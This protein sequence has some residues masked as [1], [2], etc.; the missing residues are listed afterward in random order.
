MKILSVSDIEIGF[1]YSPHI[2]DRFKDVDLI[3]SCGD[4]PFYYLEYIVS[5]LNRPLY[6]VLGNHAQQIEDGPGGPRYHPWGAYDLHA[7]TTCYEGLL[8]AGMQGSLQ[9]N[10]GPYQYTQGEMWSMVLRLAPA[11]FLNRVRYGRY[12]D[13]FVSHA[14]PWDVHDKPDRPHRG[15][16]AFRWLH[17]VFRPAYHLHGHIHV[18]RSDTITETLLYQTRVIN[19]YGYRETQVDQK[20]LQEARKNVDAHSFSDAEGKDAV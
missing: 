11:L 12:L 16:K 3:I 1:I 8:L 7:R 5:V 18:Y 4:L 19:T 20:R 14:P 2:T 9:Y 10:F 6:H 17:R 13:V 15:F